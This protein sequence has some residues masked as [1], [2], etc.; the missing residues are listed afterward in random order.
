[1]AEGPFSGGSRARK[2]VPGFSCEK[3]GVIEIKRS[4]QKKMPCGGEGQ[5]NARD[6]PPPRATQPA[7]DRMGPQDQP[8]QPP[9]PPRP[10]LWPNPAPGPCAQVPSAY[11]RLAL[12]GH[13][14]G[15]AG[16]RGSVVKGCLPG[17]ER[18]LPCP[19]ATHP[20]LPSHNVKPPPP[21]TS[22]PEGGL[23][24]PRR[25]PLLPHL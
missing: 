3:Q 4:N 7:E 2:T 15:P 9:S 18:A 25:F 6:P 14:G 21:R 20:P 16:H 5:S 22:L 10:L 1:M 8:P 17:G 19:Q 12:S 24:P 13:P 23:A 11:P